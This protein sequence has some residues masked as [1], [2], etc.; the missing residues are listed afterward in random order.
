[1]LWL[2]KINNTIYKFI[3]LRNETWRKWRINDFEKR[4]NRLHYGP[5]PCVRLSDR[6]F[7]YPVRAIALKQNGI[8]KTKL[9]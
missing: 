1:V 6:A 5:G 4:A 2:E 9:A 7:V 8:E 3:T